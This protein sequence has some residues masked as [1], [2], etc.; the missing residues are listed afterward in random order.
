MN[1]LCLF[2]RYGTEKYLDSY[3]ELQEWYKKNMNGVDVSFWI[4]DNKIEASYSGIDSKTGAR[5]LSGDNQF[6]EFSGWQRIIDQYRDEIQNYDIVHFVTETFNTLYTG[7]LNNFDIMQLEYVLNEPICLGHIDYYD[8]PIVLFNERSQ[9]WIR[10]CFFFIS[11][12]VLLSFNNF[13]GI[14]NKKIFFNDSKEDFK[15]DAPLSE[16]YKSYILSWLN[17]QKIQGVM[18]HSKIEN[19]QQLK[20]KALAIMN[21]HMLSIN[22]RKNGIKLVDFRD[23]YEEIMSSKFTYIWSKLK[24]ILFHFKAKYL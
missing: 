22:M 6:R 12:D 7:Y 4:I 13:V 21:E 10:C 23:L 15:N 14:K 18:W 5:L 24:S 19:F 20:S 16:N 9:H 11:R 17:G 1:I 2:L 3:K 8:D